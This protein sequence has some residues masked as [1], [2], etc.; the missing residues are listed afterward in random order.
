MSGKHVENL[1]EDEKDE[2]DKV[3]NT[4]NN[5]EILKNNTATTPV[6]VS[7]SSKPRIESPLL[8]NNDRGD[9]LNNSTYLNKSAEEPQKLPLSETENPT[10]INVQI[11]SGDCSNNN[12]TKNRDRD[13]HYYKSCIS[14]ISSDIETKIECC[15]KYKIE[16]ENS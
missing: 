1:V 4:C 16:L 6:R 15:R 3:Q 10:A 14:N 7:L 11:A 13:G 5:T 12:N 9:G 2:G 8:V